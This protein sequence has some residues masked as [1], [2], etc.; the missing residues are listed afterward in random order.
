MSFKCRD[1]SVIDSDR[2]VTKHFSFNLSQLFSVLISSSDGTYRTPCLQ[3]Y[4]MNSPRAHPWKQELKL[5]LQYKHS[6]GLICTKGSFVEIVGMFRLTGRY[7]RSTENKRK[8]EKLETSH[9]C[10]DIWGFSQETFFFRWLSLS[11]VRGE[12]A[13][14]CPHQK[15]KK[16][17]KRGQLKICVSHTFH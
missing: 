4:T 12:D 8:R 13:R 15:R 14:L 1:H 11:V 17:K 2:C 3:R 9:F 6:L 10:S 5:R 7:F 16:K